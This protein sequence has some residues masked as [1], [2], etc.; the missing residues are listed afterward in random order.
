M[1]LPMAVLCVFGVALFP[2]FLNMFLLF[3]LWLGRWDISIPKA[4]LPNISILIACYNEENSIE[5]T[6]CNIL[7]TCYPS[8]IELLVI[9][10]GS[11]DDTYLTL[12]SLQEEFRD[13]PP[14]SPYF[15]T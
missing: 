12:K 13:Y 3:T 4:K 8:H 14:H 1:P 7:A 9:D 5:R 10:D 11:N 6:I 15:P 2:G